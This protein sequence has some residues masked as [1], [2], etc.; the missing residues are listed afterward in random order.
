LRGQT[1]KRQRAAKKTWDPSKNPDWLDEKF[2]W[3]EIQPN[4]AKVMVSAISKALRVSILYASGIR[5]GKRRPHPRH[6]LILAR[7]AG[8]SSDERS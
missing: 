1:E 3:E 7:L 2:Y 4:L 5:A 6:W 8:V